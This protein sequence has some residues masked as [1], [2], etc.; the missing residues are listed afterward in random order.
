MES[1]ADLV[2]EDMTA[3]NGML[4]GSMGGGRQQGEAMHGNGIGGTG[5]ASCFPGPELRNKC[6]AD[7]GLPAARARH[8]RGLVGAEQL[9]VDDG[10]FLGSMEGRRQ[11]GEAV[12]RGSEVVGAAS[13]FQG[14]R[15][16]SGVSGRCV[17]GGCNG[18]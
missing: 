4:G 7:V 13:C 15:A 18:R 6:R 11:Q 5:A 10:E 9:G 3:D 8:L 17:S 12:G 2:R 1:R 16:S 14:V